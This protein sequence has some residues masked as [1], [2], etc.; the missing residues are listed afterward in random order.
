METTVVTNV[1]GSFVLTQLRD[2]AGC[3]I[4]KKIWFSKIDCMN[5]FLENYKNFYFLCDSSNS[6]RI[7]NPEKSL[8]IVPLKEDQ[9]QLL[10]LA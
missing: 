9:G 7:S 1:S 6:L 10:P 2:T 8:F 3:L 4:C 5:Q